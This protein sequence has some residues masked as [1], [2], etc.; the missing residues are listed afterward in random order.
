[1]E[2][3]RINVYFCYFS[4][5]LSL[6]PLRL[7]IHWLLGVQLITTDFIIQNNGSPTTLPNARRHED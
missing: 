6:M 4:L 2:H 5:H 7:H 1:M 3:E